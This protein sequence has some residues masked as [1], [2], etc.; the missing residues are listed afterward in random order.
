MFVLVSR[1][2]G[3]VV[4]GVQG[5][6]RQSVDVAAGRSEKLS[7]MAADLRLNLLLNYRGGR[8]GLYGLVG[9]GG[10]WGRLEWERVGPASG[11]IPGSLATEA[12]AWEG[13]SG[14]ILLN[15]GLGASL[16]HHLDLRLEA[17]FLHFLKLP[18]AA[19]RTFTPVMLTVL[20]RF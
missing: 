1:L 2:A 18:E 11:Q 6:E 9:V 10:L 5:G 19:D 8:P 16:G 3:E 15:L 4:L 14:G 13:R 20:Y 7:L 17:P 12:E